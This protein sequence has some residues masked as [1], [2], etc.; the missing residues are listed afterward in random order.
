VADASTDEIHAAMDRLA[1]QQE[2][3]EKKLAEKHLNE[4]V[5][6]HRRRCLT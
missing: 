3:I 1:D 4:S 5:N 2:A 6:P